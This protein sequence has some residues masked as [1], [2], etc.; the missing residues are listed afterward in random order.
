MG[1]GG[2]SGGDNVIED[3]INQC[4]RRRASRGRGKLQPPCTIP[5]LTT[6]CDLQIVPRAEEL[7]QPLSFAR[8]GVDLGLL[9]WNGH[10]RWA[11]SVGEWEGQVEGRPSSRVQYLVDRTP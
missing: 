4:L 5:P 1:L 10:G 8:W 7:S 3:G 6:L 11:L 9:Q 2:L